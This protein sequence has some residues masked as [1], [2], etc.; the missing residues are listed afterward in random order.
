MRLFAR[1]EF[2]ITVIVQKDDVVHACMFSGPSFHF[3]IKVREFGQQRQSD[4]SAS[5]L[6]CEAILA[7]L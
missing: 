2:L 5:R 1:G 3:K 4:N 6:T 7:I